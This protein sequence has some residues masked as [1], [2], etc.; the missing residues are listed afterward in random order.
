MIKLT[1]QD[2]ELDQSIIVIGTSTGGP[3]ALQQ[4]L[5]ELP[6]QL[7]APILIVQHIPSGFTK[8]LAQRLNSLMSF[9][10]K[11]AEE[12]E[13]IYDNTVYIAPG[14]CHMELRSSTKE[15]VIKLTKDAPLRGHRPSVDV[16][17]F[18][19]AK[20]KHRNKIAVILTGMG[21]DGAEGIRKLKS[22]DPSSVVIAEAEET[23]IVYGMPKAAV[24]TKCVDYV[25][26]LPQV[27]AA[28]TNIM[29]K[30]GGN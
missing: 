1:S 14:D 8:S 20:I 5:G 28:I 3:R 4:V 12:N 11:E 23:A 9:T 30:K 26:P 17:L 29:N 13:V 22:N 24:N 25:L 19:F 18:S 6:N 2:H 16:L 10:V 27:G 7:P 21:K 15:L